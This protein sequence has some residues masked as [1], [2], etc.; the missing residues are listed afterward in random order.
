M[1]KRGERPE[2]D[3][4]EE[5]AMRL[6][7]DDENKEEEVDDASLSRLVEETPSRRRLVRSTRRP[8]SRAR[9]WSIRRG[10]ARAG[11]LK[12]GERN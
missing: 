2:E 12:E 8:V 3:A 9:R 1:E 10:R 11:E 5:L 6:A 4:S 7:A